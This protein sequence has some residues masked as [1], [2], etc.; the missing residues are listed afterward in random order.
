MSTHLQWHTSKKI[1]KPKVDFDYITDKIQQYFPSGMLSL[2]TQRDVPEDQPYVCLVLNCPKY[3]FN[4]YGNTQTQTKIK[5]A[6]AN[7]TSLNNIDSSLIDHE[8]SLIIQNEST[9]ELLNERTQKEEL[10]SHVN[11]Q[12]NN[13]LNYQELMKKIFKN[14]VT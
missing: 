8:L 3:F 9:N 7:N 12:V 13:T 2:F 11:N 14:M 6:S 4:Q 1:K 10:E 5:Q